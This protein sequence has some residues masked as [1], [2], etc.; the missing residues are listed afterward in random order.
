M[1]RLLPSLAPEVSCLD[2]ALDN[3]LRSF[4]GVCGQS[5]VRECHARSSVQ[6]RAKPAERT[7][8]RL[9]SHRYGEPLC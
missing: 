6:V 1:A 9:V 4:A 5:V 2:K 8:L 3:T 7:P